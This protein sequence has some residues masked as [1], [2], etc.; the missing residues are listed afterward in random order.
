VRFGNLPQLQYLGTSER[1]MD[2]GSAHA[3]TSSRR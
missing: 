2:D 1:L 3:R